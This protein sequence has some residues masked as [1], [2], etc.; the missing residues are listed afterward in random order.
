MDTFGPPFWPLWV[1]WP[2]SW[3]PC[4]L[5]GTGSGHAWSP[6]GRTVAA[7]GIRGPILAQFGYPLTPIWDA[8]WVPRAGFCDAWQH[9]PPSIECLAS[10][11][12][13]WEAFN[14]VPRSRG[15]CCRRHLPEDIG[16]RRSTVCPQPLAPGA[17]RAL[18]VL[19]F[20]PGHLRQHFSACWHMM[21]PTGGP[22]SR[23]NRGRAKRG[24]KILV[25]IILYMITGRRDCEKA[26]KS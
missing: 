3:Y 23:K 20:A 15:H 25:Y 26:N 21:G 2:R 16:S 24:P 4:E 5:L 22:G 1:P 14:Q 6:L 8:L 19:L 7:T 12:P 11:V 17:G 13:P 10:L 9:T 18:G